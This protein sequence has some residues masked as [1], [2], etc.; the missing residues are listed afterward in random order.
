MKGSTAF[1]L[2]F[3]INIVKSIPNHSLRTFSLE[4]SLVPEA[5]YPTQIQQ[6]ALAYEHILMTVSPENIVLAGDSAGGTIIFSLLL[7]ISRPCPDLKAPSPTLAAPKSIILISP[8]CQIDSRQA[9]TSLPLRQVDEDCL[10]AAML[11]EYALLY[12]EATNPKSPPSLTFPLRFYLMAFANQYRQ[13]LNLPYTSKWITRAKLA[14]LQSGADPRV[15]DVHS[16][17]CN[18]PYRNPFAA[19]RHEEWL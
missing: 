13:L 19:L 14:V 2:E 16:S 17:L 4:Y 7:H 1:Y 3:L 18:S 10:D 8:W 6:L 9:F 15:L 5:R 12:T 11:D